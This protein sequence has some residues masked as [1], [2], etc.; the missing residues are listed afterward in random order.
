MDA[1]AIYETAVFAGKQAAAKVNAEL[2]PE[3]DRGLDC[4]FAWVV[5]KPARGPLVSW[6]KK[7]GR[8]R[9]H[10]SGGWC[11]WYSEFS[12][13][14]QSV[15]VHEAAAQAFCEVLTAAGLHAYADSRLD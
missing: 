2:G 13:A 7:N 1:Q 3:R 15:S 6:A 8:G 4:G 5:V 11:F 10:Y 12:T 9:R 14:T